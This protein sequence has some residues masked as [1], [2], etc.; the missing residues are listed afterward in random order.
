MDMNVH[1]LK[2]TVSLPAW[3]D[4]FVNDDFARDGVHVVSSQPSVSPVEKWATARDL[5][6][7]KNQLIINK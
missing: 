4:V 3:P 2:W 1:G 5:Q 7:K 6:N